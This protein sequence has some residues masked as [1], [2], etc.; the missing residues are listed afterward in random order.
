[1]TSWLTLDEGLAAPGLRIVP[2][3][4][5]VPSPWSEL[6]R[7]LFHV[8][9]VPFTLI[10]ARD[11][12]S[13]LTGLKAATGHDV[14]PVVLWNQERPRASWIEQLA[15]AERLA[16]QPRLLPEQPI[17]RAR[18]TGLLAELCTEGGF[19]WSRR[20][21]MIDRLLHDSRYGDR[22]RAI[23][24]YLGAKYGYSDPSVADATRRCEAVLAAFA[25]LA[26]LDTPYLVGPT[27]TALDLG[28][29]A[30]AALIRPLPE[31]AC[32]MHPLWRELY[33]WTPVETA[34]AAVDALLARR[35]RVYEQ[36]L[37]LP[38]VL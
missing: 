9:K 8:K 33:T 25:A 19:G 35:D 30:F 37:E 28:W 32:S 22:E 34:P 16:P 5:G 21:V 2:V 7:A 38:I 6:C 4:S 18:V 14:L 3:R 1:M 29:A 23:G 36:W 13:G 24:H 27:L 15:L 31:S 17:E 20:I 12:K 11:P 26:E 10:S